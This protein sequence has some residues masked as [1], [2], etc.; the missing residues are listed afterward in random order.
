MKRRKAYPM[1]SLPFNRAFTLIE[2]LIVIAIVGILSGFVIV[3]M[4]GA[5]NS[6]K[7]ARR[8]ADLSTISKAIL[9]YSA[10]N[11]NAYPYTATT[12]ACNLCNNDSCSNPCTGFYANIQ[13]Y[14]P[15]I[16][17]DPNGAY[18]TYTYSA[19]P[20]FVLQSTLSNGASYQYDSIAGFATIIYASTCTAAT[21]AQV[22][23]SPITISS[24]EET[25]QCTYLSGAGTT[26]WTVPNG[27]TSAQI[28]IV[29]GGGGGG[30]GAPSTI[31]AGGGGAGGILGGTL[32]SLSGPYNLVVGAGGA[33]VNSN[34]ARG[35]SGTNSSFGSFIAYGGGG[36]GGGQPS[37]GT[38]GL[39][40]G[41]G[42]GGGA[43]TTSAYVPGST[44]QTTQSPLT[45]YGANG[46]AGAGGLAGHGGGVSFSSSITGSSVIYS[47]PGTNVDNGTGYAGVNGNGEGGDGGC[48]K[49][50][51]GGNGTVIVRYTHP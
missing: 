36:G 51:A 9:E 31:S 10:Q 1:K 18:Y 44:T 6:A 19:T 37:A 28:L 35:N 34:Y 49:G 16:P 38:P 39:N 22:S 21:N 41:C 3:S 33:E 23:C 25:C 46:T 11:N 2:L 17:I 15:N 5:I 7:D 48:N 45:G 40:G 50:Y 26:S 32:T 42:G 29:G 47:I 24:T 20:K 8:K 13:P 43:N 14:M 27:V 30:K 4:N 12:T